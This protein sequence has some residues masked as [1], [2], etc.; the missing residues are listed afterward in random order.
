[1]EIK[2]YTEKGTKFAL[3]MIEIGRKYSMARKAFGEFVNKL[4]FDAWH[5]HDGWVMF[6]NQSGRFVINEQFIDITWI[7]SH[8]DSH[9]SICPK[10]GHKLIIPSESPNGE[11]KPFIAHCYEVIEYNHSGFVSD[12]IKLKKIGIKE[13]VFNESEFNYKLL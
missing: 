1:M 10:V 8:E 11:A 5:C 7:E 12:R 3:E 4:G 6:N 2:S 13:V 9:S